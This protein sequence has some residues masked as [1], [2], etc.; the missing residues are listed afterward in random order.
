MDTITNTDNIGDTIRKLRESQGLTQEELANRVEMDQSTI[1]KIE[2][3]HTDGSLSSLRKIVNAL[4]G[5]ILITKE[6]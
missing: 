5:H 4:N 6:E 3:G 2:K 1:S